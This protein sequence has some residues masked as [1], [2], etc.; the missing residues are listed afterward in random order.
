MSFWFAGDGRSR[1]RSRSGSEGEGSSGVKPRTKQAS[2]DDDSD[3]ETG[4][5]PKPRSDPAPR[6]TQPASRSA[7]SPPAPLF[8]LSSSEPTP[9]ARARADSQSPSG[10]QES[11]SRKPPEN[12]STLNT[13]SS[14]VPSSTTPLRTSQE[15]AT[16]APAGETL[17]RTPSQSSIQSHHSTTVAQDSSGSSRD[18]YSRNNRHQGSRPV[19]ALVPPRESILSPNPAPAPRSSGS[20]RNRDNTGSSGRSSP[21]SHHPTA[22]PSPSPKLGRAAQPRQTRDELRY[23]DDAS[24][25]DSDSEPD[26]SHKGNSNLAASS[27][28]MVPPTP[29]SLNSSVGYI[30]VAPG[31]PAP[32]RAAV[33]EPEPAD[34]DDSP[35]FV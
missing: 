35:A 6:Q 27:S 2:L 8:S 24:D 31:S 11:D 13:S 22:S 33:A 17:K 32:H 20:I 10:T 4:Q 9:A 15:S 29:T 21:M 30:D 14:P 16:P 7:P 12:L 19:I 25:V 34:D 1:S 5:S 23:L 26:N 3:T 18:L 28:N